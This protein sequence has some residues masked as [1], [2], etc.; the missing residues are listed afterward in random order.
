MIIHFFLSELTFVA[1]ILLVRVIFDSTW[2]IYIYIVSKNVSMSSFEI[3]FLIII[4][5]TKYI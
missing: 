3:G 4:A 2:Y 5:K 1:W